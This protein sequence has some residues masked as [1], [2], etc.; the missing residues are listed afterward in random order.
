MAL[1]YPR[2]YP[3]SVLGVLDGVEPTEFDVDRGVARLRVADHDLL[4]LHQRPP[5]IEQ[6]LHE[7]DRLL[8]M[9]GRAVAPR[10]VATGRAAEGDE[11]IVAELNR[12]AVP[13]AGGLGPVNPEA[14]ATELGRALRRLHEVGIDD[15]PFESASTSHLRSAEAAIATGAVEPAV[16]GPYVGRSPMELL[17]ILAGLLDELPTHD[18]VFVHGGLGVDRIWLA[19]EGR[20]TFTGW[21]QAGLGD[22][23]LDLAAVAVSVGA[24]L[25]LAVVAP[26]LDAYGLDDIHLV[27]LDAHQLLVHLMP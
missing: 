21:E 13:L 4:V 8:W 15:C 27:S 2:A 7:A 11:T 23:H 26:F 14:L 5:E 1:A 9:D 3:P 22:R 16:E 19:P 17:G 20:I 25:G 18:P 6:V 12:L 10:L 24:E